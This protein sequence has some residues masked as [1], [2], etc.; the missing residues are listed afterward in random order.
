[1]YTVSLYEA[2]QR[3]RWLGFP[4]VVLVIPGWNDVITSEGDLYDDLVRYPHA[5]V[6]E[7]IT[8]PDNHA[9]IA[10]SLDNAIGNMMAEAFHSGKIN[11]DDHKRL[12]ET[13]VTINVRSAQLPE[14]IEPFYIIGGAEES[15]AILYWNDN[16]DSAS[17]SQIDLDKAADY[18]QKVHAVTS[19]QPWLEEDVR[20]RPKPVWTDVCIPYNIVLAKIDAAV[21]FLHDFGWHAKLRSRLFR[22]FNNLQ[23]YQGSDLKWAKLLKRWGVADPDVIFDDD[24][25]KEVMSIFKRNLPNMKPKLQSEFDDILGIMQYITLKFI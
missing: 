14:D 15:K 3:S 2:L 11:Q 4:R 10:G 7:I 22:D 5:R 19:L 18:F 16:S 8:E 9:L 25:Y 1:M 21:F 17:L 23:N 24:K 12:T 20:L 6:L 13:P